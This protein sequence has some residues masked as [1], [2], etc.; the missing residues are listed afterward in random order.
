M[1]VGPLLS[2][3]FGLRVS[4][5]GRNVTAIGLTRGHMY[6]QSIRL[7]LVSDWFGP[8]LQT[9]SCGTADCI[10]SI[11]VRAGSPLA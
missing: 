3:S 8:Q 6:K 5:L 9:S 4:F 10:H 7:V 1:H 2:K 11:G